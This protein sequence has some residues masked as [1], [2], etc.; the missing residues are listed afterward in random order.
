MTSIE[1]E[2]QQNCEAC[3]TIYKHIATLRDLGAVFDLSNSQ[4]PY[5]LRCLN[6]HIITEDELFR[7]S[8]V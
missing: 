7:R 3:A 6:G 2:E 4:R 5:P 1:G 8:L